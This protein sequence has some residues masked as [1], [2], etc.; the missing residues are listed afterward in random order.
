[1]CL[2]NRGSQELIQALPSGGAFCILSE[3]ILSEVILSVGKAPEF[4]IEG[5]DLSSG[6]VKLRIIRTGCRGGVK[7]TCLTYHLFEEK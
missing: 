4:C 5:L 2:D 6:I 3:V 7:K 1:M